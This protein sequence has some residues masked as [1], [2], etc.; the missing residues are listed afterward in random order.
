MEQV[1]HATDQINK[2]FFEERLRT[3]WYF[4]FK[5]LILNFHFK[6]IGQNT[7]PHIW[8]NS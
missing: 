7:T 8:S 4:A 2:H 6:W 3:M 1:K 5:S